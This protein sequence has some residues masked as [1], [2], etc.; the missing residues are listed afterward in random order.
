MASSTSQAPLPAGKVSWKRKRP[1]LV[2]CGAAGSAR[3]PVL[4]LRRLVDVVADHAAENCTGCA[5][6]DRALDLVPAGRCADR[7]TCYRTD[8]SITL[9]VLDDRWLPW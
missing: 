1:A 5:T 2:E 8:R 9:G 7:C 6:N 4:V 3:K